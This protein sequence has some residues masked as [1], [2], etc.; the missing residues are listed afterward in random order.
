MNIQT[1]EISRPFLV[2]CSAT[3]Y[4]RLS[5]HIDGAT[6][7]CRSLNIARNVQRGSNWKQA[8]STENQLL[9]HQVVELSE[10]FQGPN[11]RRPV[12]KKK[13]L[14]TWL[15]VDSLYPIKP[16]RDLHLTSLDS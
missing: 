6:R 14:S 15:L 9:W 10:V 11:L 1:D 5:L 12:D 7:R 8:F 4:H 13:R 3:Y 2:I 16:L